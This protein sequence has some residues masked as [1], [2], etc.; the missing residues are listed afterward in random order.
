[1][2]GVAQAGYNTQQQFGGL[3]NALGNT[4]LQSGLLGNVNW[5][6][7]ARTPGAAQHISETQDYYG[8]GWTDAQKAQNY[9]NNGY[10]QAS[11]LT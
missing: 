11:D 6:A 3:Y 9:Y 4:N 2:P 10:G 7:Y 5:D 1:M 8:T